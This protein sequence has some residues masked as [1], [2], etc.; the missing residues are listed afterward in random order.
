MNVCYF[1]EDM[2]LGDMIMN[3]R[4][5]MSLHLYVYLF[6]SNDIKMTIQHLDLVLKILI[7]RFVTVVDDDD[8]ENPLDTNGNTEGREREREREKKQN[9][10]E[11]NVDN[12]E[13]SCSLR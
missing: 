11:R 3:N 12:K 4:R 8:D 6:V 10:R 7:Y 9:I 2:P 1:S 5:E 13:M